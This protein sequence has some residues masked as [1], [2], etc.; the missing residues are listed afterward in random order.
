MDENY[1][2]TLINSE[3]KKYVYRLT[4]WVYAI[5]NLQIFYKNNLINYYFERGKFTRLQVTI[6][7][8]IKISIIIHPCNMP[9]FYN[10]KCVK[11]R[12]NVISLKLKC[13]R[14]LIIQLFV[15]KSNLIDNNN[16]MVIFIN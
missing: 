16:I 8:N 1:L 6:F 4:T 10:Y 3:C 13:F 12:R 9:I 5:P 15:V 7:I 2:P 14:L 11:I